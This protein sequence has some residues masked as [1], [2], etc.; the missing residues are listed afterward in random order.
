MI[1]L[2]EAEEIMEPDKHEKPTTFLGKVVF[3]FWL[4]IIFI[5]ALVALAVFTSFHH[6]S[7]GENQEDSEED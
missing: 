7:E 2:D 6:P 3:Y 5:I 4:V 1:P